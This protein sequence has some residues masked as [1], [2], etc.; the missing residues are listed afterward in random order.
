MEVDGRWWSA[1][2]ALWSDLRGCCGTEII[3]KNRENLP[4]ALHHWGGACRP[5]R[6]VAFVNSASEPEKRR[7]VPSMSSRASAQCG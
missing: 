2:A 5:G 4:E 3:V 6:T 7:H 1:A